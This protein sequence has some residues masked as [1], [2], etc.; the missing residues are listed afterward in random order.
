MM[1]TVEA[2]K[3]QYM[4]NVLSLVALKATSSNQDHDTND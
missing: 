1:C 2:K 3:K 4:S